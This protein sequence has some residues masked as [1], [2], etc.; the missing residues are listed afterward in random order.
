MN[1]KN[2]TSVFC[3]FLFLSSTLVSYTPTNFNKPYDINFRMAE[4]KGTKFS[5]GTNVEYGQTSKS[6]DGNEKRVEMLRMHN[7]SESALSMLLGAKR[8][9]DIHQLANLL[10]PAFAPAL[11][12]GRRGH[13]LLNGKFEG[14]DFTFWGKYR[15]P[16][17][18]IPGKFDVFVYC[19]FR[20]LRVGDIK[21][22]D[23][24]QNVL[25]ADLDVKRYLTDDINTVASNLGGLDLKRWS[26]TGLGDLIF[27]LSW[28]MDFKQTKEHLK[29]V[30]ITTRLGLTVPS[31]NE[32]SEDK[33]FS[34]PLGNDGAWSVP[35]T[36]G[37]DLDFVNKVKAGLEFSA[38]F[39]F[40]ETRVRRLKTHP[41][42]TDFL[43]LHKG[44]A[45]KS[46]GVTWQF[47]L[48]VEVG[49]FL[50]GLS[51]KI[52]YQFLKHDDDRLTPQSNDFSYNIIN[53]A[54][55][56]QEW[57]MQNFVFQ[58]NYDFFKEA[59][60]SLL[61]P[62]ISLFY[63]LPVTGKRVINPHTFGGQLAFNF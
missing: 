12:D 26:T 10:I 14:L 51:A 62:Q 23:Q 45:T 3:S 56:L 2:I 41:K 37:L 27:M 49:H 24:T 29:N 55:S 60:N 58:L 57:G 1:I 31:G 30:R 4:W 54:E 16:I 46:L 35:F 43:L 36:L 15:L 9:S 53:T 50:R 11:D 13:F 25:N 63:K 20:Y 28:H 6:R 40:D 32:K 8:G 44:E 59:K 42:Q 33:T 61:K 38:L 21:W 17:E 52:A 48:F 7:P 34:L 5:F 18:A 47:N 39:P 19:P 22:N